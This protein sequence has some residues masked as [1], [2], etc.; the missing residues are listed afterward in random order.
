MGNDV[1]DP[2]RIQLLIID[3]EKKHK[4]FAAAFTFNFLRV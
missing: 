2:N 1:N 4:Y 3:H